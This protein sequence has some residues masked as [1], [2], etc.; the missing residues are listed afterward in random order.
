MGLLHA[1]QIFVLVIDAHM[2]AGGTSSGKNKS[3]RVQ[4]VLS[5]LQYK[6]IAHRYLCENISNGIESNAYTY[7]GY[8]EAAVKKSRIFFSSKF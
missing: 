5:L 8:L 2:G 1:R 7:N 6:N 4:A 3:E